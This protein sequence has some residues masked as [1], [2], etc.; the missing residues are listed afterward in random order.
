[1]SRPWLDWT[2]VLVQTDHLLLQ[3]RRLPQRLTA[4]RTTFATRIS[5]SRSTCMWTAISSVSTRRCGTI[6]FGQCA[7]SQESGTTLRPHSESDASSYTHV[8]REKCQTPMHIMT[9]RPLLI[10]IPHTSWNYHI[11]TPPTIVPFRADS[12]G[13]GLLAAGHRDHD[14]VLSMSVLLS[15]PSAL[16]GGEFV[17]WSDRLPVAHKLRQG[18]AVLFHS[19][20]AHNVAQVVC[21]VRR[22]LVIEVWRGETNEKNRFK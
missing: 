17:T 9:I 1:M 4:D 6:Y 22:S 15:D 18:D 20:R 11:H 14:S 5:I 2:S 8:R 12:I 19:C 13:G 3:A 10:S 21:G 16:V 7:S